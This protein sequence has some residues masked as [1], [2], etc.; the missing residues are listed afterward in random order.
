VK[1]F[2]PPDVAA[3]KAKGDVKGVVKALDQED[4]RDMRRAACAALGEMHDPRAVAAL[5]RTLEDP[6]GWMRE[7]AAAALGAQRDEAAAEP[8]GA[9]VAR[10]T[11]AHIAVLAAEALAGIG[12]ERADRILLDIASCA[13][14]PQ[15]ETALRAL[16]TSARAGEPHVVEALRDLAANGRFGSLRPTALG[17][18]SALDDPDVI[19]F[20]NGALADED[21]DVRLVAVRT[22]ERRVPDVPAKPKPRVMQWPLRMPAAGMHRS[23]GAGPVPAEIRARCAVADHN[24]TWAVRLGP[25]AVEPLQWALE[26]A[27]GDERAIAERAAEALAEIGTEDA[28]RVLRHVGRTTSGA[29]ATATAPPVHDGAHE[30]PAALL[31]LARS[32][33]SGTA[34]AGALQRLSD[35]DHPD[36]VALADAALA[37]PSAEVRRA[38]VGVIE[39]RAG[40]RP[41]EPQAGRKPAPLRMP[42][43]GSR[44]PV[45]GAPVPAEIQARCAVA[46]RDWGWAT[47]LGPVSVEPLRSL[48]RRGWTRDPEAK[49]AAIGVLAR[50]GG[51]ESLDAIRPALQSRAPVVVAAAARALRDVHDPWT[52]S[53]VE[54]ADERIAELMREGLDAGMGLDRVGRVAAVADVATSRT[55][56]TRL[57]ER[58]AGIREHW[59]E[60]GWDPDDTWSGSLARKAREERELARALEYERAAEV[61]APSTSRDDAEDRRQRLETLAADARQGSRTACRELRELR[62][63]RPGPVEETIREVVRSLQGDL[64]YEPSWP[65]PEYDDDPWGYDAWEREATEVRLR[66]AGALAA[67]GEQEGI[68]FLHARLVEDG[69]GR[70]LTA[71]QEIGGA[72]AIEVLRAAARELEGASGQFHSPLA[73]SNAERASS[74]RMLREAIQRALDEVESAPG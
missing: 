70:A 65:Q 39:R 53:E 15:A 12:T 42:D 22:I 17:R 69:D 21:E 68:E 63:L 34:R 46:D 1:L 67:L 3:M 73:L 59:A 45:A 29:P 52:R 9:L 36:V 11:M 32:G 26:R 31:E 6:D 35:L 8:L 60:W 23:A 33:P 43:A 49:A 30:A 10:E 50:I 4:D 44:R 18:L 41:T 47:R 2:G 24:W 28:E 55:V 20:A 64:A 37:D 25:V 13:D 14:E 19:D 57:R 71:L 51:P 56:A 16:C 72:A 27:S 62:A 58:A 48:L 38:A 61:L 74:V 7:T 5:V 66:G 54:A 40:S